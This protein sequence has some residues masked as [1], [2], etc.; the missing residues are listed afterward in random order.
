MGIINRTS[1]MLTY[2]GFPLEIVLS[3]IDSS[4]TIGNFM[5]S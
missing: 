4:K 3:S 5:K 2:F 1:Y